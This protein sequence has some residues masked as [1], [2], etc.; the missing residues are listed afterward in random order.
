MR[1]KPEM[2]RN[3]EVACHRHDRWRDLAEE[4]ETEAMIIA[5]KQ[6]MAM[7]RAARTPPL[8][9]VRPVTPSASSPAALPVERAGESRG[10]TI[11]NP[12]PLS[13]APLPS[14]KQTQAALTAAAKPG[15]LTAAT[16]KRDAAVLDALEKLGKGTGGNGKYTLVELATHLNCPIASL[17]NLCAHLASMS[18][19]GRIHHESG[20]GLYCSIAAPHMPAVAV[21]TQEVALNASELLESPAAVEAPASPAVAPEAPTEPAASSKPVSV[22]E[23]NDN[24]RARRD[25]ILTKAFDEMGPGEVAKNKYTM[26][27]FSRYLDVGVEVLWKVRAHL[28]DMRLRG[29]VR[30]VGDGVYAAVPEWQ[31]VTPVPPMPQDTY[32]HEEVLWLS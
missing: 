15:S 16:D 31:R 2:M 10:E 27:D 19:R 25:R 29:L 28:D 1:R 3:P 21:E 18:S 9:S 32:E 24:I 20:T 30:F 4:A 23:T 14:V 13:A 8:P 5:I 6:K 22:I 7:A 17:Q 11:S 26:M 12:L